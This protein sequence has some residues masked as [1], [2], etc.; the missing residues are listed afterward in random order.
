MLL[1][2][3]I[4]PPGLNGVGALARVSAARLPQIREPS[5]RDVDNVGRIFAAAWRRRS[6]GAEISAK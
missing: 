1:D 4:I 2:N 6:V 5:V 3:S